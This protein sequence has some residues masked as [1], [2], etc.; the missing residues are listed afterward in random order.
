MTPQL[1][2][3]EIQLREFADKYELTRAE[4]ES[5]GLECIAACELAKRI[6]LNRKTVYEYA[7]RGLIPCRRVGRRVVF[8]LPSVAAWL[9]GSPSEIRPAT[10]RASR[11]T[12]KPA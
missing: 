7:A 6:G 11:A 1:V 10:G 9:T 12:P 2:T 8:H 4:R 3:D 5:I